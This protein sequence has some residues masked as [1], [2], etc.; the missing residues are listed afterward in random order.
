MRCLVCHA[1]SPRATCPQCGYD[2]SQPGA[3]D[4]QRILAAREEFRA[5]TLEYAPGSRVTLRDRLLPW[6]GLALGI[7]LLL[8]WLRACSTGGRLI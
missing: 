2:A 6:A 4:P 5:R 1:E 8:L 7:L 3:R